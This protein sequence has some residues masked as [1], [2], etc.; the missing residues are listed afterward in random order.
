MSSEQNSQNGQNG[1]N[2]YNGYK[3]NGAQLNG[4]DSSSLE[5]IDKRYATQSQSYG[6]LKG[7]NIGSIY[8]NYKEARKYSQRPLPTTMGDG[9]YKQVVQR[10]TLR[11][12][13]R[14]F[15]R[16]GTL[17]FYGYGESS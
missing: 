13:L 3:T 4:V 2:G 9:T 10:T 1:H 7:G 5:S 17:S 16:K 14:T 8:S 15:S 6:Q 12:D 11:Q